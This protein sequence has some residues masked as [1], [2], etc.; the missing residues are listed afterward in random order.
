MTSNES[1]RVEEPASEVVEYGHDPWGR[2]G[3]NGHPIS[4]RRPGSMGDRAT[5]PRE[6]A[7]I[8]KLLE[9]AVGER[10]R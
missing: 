7:P 4:V 10:Y 5:L 6:R 9:T 2:T 1:V 3:E 8:S